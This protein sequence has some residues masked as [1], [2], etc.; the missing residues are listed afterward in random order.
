MRYEFSLVIRVT[1]ALA[2]FI[3]PLYIFDV[4]IFQRVFEQITFDTVYAFLDKSGVEPEPGSFSVRYA[5]SILGGKATV[6][7]VKYCVTASAYYLLTLL[8]VVTMSIALW[9]RIVMFLI[10]SALIFGMNIVRIIVLINILL[11]SQ[12]VFK[13]A[14][15]A[16]SLLLSVGYVLLVWFFLSFL[17]KVKAV[18]FYSDI[19][20]LIHEMSQEKMKGVRKRW[21][22]QKNYL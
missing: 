2:L 4:N 21:N 19:K 12:G 10:G 20:F 17:F 8:C 9:K 7:I 11:N 13:P 22:I 6:N 1:L 16:F 3:V 14:H 18:P 5:I 15:F